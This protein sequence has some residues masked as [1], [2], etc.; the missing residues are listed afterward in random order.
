MQNTN[1][2]IKKLDMYI[3]AAKIF[4]VLPSEENAIFLDSSLVNE[5][6]HY[7]I[8]GRKPY[9]KLEK[10]EDRFYINDT[11]ETSISFENYLRS[12]LDKQ[13]TANSSHLP[14]ASGALDIFLTNMAVGSWEFHLPT[15]TQ[16][17]FQMQ[18]SYFTMHLLL[19]I[20]TKKR[21]TSLPMELPNLLIYF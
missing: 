10:R 9:L 18:Y 3:P 19:K 6:G 11:E 16:S 21:V 13:K 2:I 1:T 17:L 20:V 12:Y 8:I 4:Q 14:L 7:S 5:L 15:K